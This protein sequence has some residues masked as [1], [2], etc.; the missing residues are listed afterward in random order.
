MAAIA[1][2]KA[3]RRGVVAFGKD[4]DREDAKR[5]LEDMDEWAQRDRA[6]RGVKSN[7]ALTHLYESVV[8]VLQYL[9]TN[10]KILQ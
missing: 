5:L 10:T 2:A 9:S 3:E 4:R 8:T 1:K 6:R 7:N